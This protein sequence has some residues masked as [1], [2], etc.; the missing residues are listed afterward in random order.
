MSKRGGSVGGGAAKK[1][2]PAAGCG[3]IKGFFNKP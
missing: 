1:H 3:D 2:K